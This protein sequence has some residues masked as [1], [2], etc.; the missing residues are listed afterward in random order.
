MVFE[1]VL[2]TR[3]GE[4]SNDDHPDLHGKVDRRS[5]YLEENRVRT[6]T[7][8]IGYTY[9]GVPM[10]LVLL[11]QSPACIFQKPECD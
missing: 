6:G 1:V 8:R 7:R 2:S 9:E 5:R 11:R 3:I 10:V 4:V